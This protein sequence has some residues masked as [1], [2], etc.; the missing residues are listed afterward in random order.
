MR[1]TDSLRRGRY[2]FPTLFLGALGFLTVYWEGLG[3]RVEAADQSGVIKV[4]F[5]YGSEKK[6]W[7]EWATDGGAKNKEGKVEKVANKD[8]FNLG[9]HQVNGKRIVVETVPLGSGETID[10]VING[11]R[12][13]H[14]V[15]P[16]SGAFIKIGNARWRAELAKQGKPEQDLIGPTKNLVRSPVVIAMW[17]PMA[18]ALGWPQKP[19]GWADILSLARDDQAWSKKG[20]PEWDP[21]KFGHTHPELSNSGLISILAEVYASVQK[22]HGL[23][24]DD[25]KNPE[26]A[27]FVESI[28]ES[29][30]H[31]GSSTGFF[32]TKMFN[33]GPRY[34]SAAVMYE[35]MVIESYDRDKYKKPQFDVVAI[36]PKEGTFM[37]DHPVGIVQREWVHDEERAAAQKYL[38]FLLEEPQQKQAMVYGFRPGL[39][40]IPLVSPLDVGHG[41]DPTQPQQQLQVPSAEVM[42]AILDLWKGHCKPTNIF[43]VLDTSGSMSDND[44][45][46][47]AKIAAKSFLDNMGNRDLFTLISF[48]DAVKPPQGP[49]PLGSDR[50]KAVG[51]IDRLIPGGET[52]LYDAVEKAYELYQND[53]NKKTIPAIIVLTDG[54]NNRIKGKHVDKIEENEKPLKDLLD[55]LKPGSEKRPIRIFTIGYSLNEKDPEEKAALEAL[56]KIAAVTDGKF[57]AGTPDNIEDVMR[58]IRKFF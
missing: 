23:T 34:L 21:F 40:S 19:I 26:T 56:K 20:F 50:Q 6:D 3:D 30:V 48:S 51:S 5:V 15:S 18:E 7:I 22:D 55:K 13:A 11:G 49:F 46:T 16:A 24:L 17:K 28:E 33:S 9:N 42:N 31:Y 58:D 57:Y 2:L 27:K 38:E 45:L 32:G 53:A 47:N 43:L 44:R 25:V 10:D 8:A 36:Y 14:L 52:A 12:K 4:L 29:V 1:V 39:E 37:S 54:M 35:N 41:V